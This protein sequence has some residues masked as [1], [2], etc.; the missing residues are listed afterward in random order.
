[1]RQ[2]TIRGQLTRRAALLA[3]GAIAGGFLGARYGAKVPPVTGARSLAP[4][5]AGGMLNDA[6]LLSETPVFRHAVLAENPGQALIARLRQEL[7]EARAEGRPV[8]IGAAR[9][10]MGGHAIPPGGHAVT[11]D[12]GLVEPDT[13]KG[14][15]RVHPGARWSQVIAQLD[16]VGMSPKVMQSN[17]DFGVA[18][19]FAVNAHGWPV[20][21]GPMG[22]T[23]RTIYML[24]P[25]GELLRVSRD[26]FADLFFLA[27]GGYGMTGA[28]I[29]MEVEMVPNRRLVPTFQKIAAKDFAPFFV[30]AIETG[31][32]NMAY[33]R[34]NVDRARFF[35]DAL[36]ITYRETRDQEDLPPAAGS[37]LVSR[38]SACIFRAQLMNE[39]AKELRWWFETD[40]GPMIGAGEVT[41]NS[42][43]N[44]PVIT[45]DD[46]DPSRTD[47]LH[48][49]FVPPE[50][51][52][53]FVA[54]CQDVIPSSYQEM[55]NITLRF[56]RADRESVLAY[57]PGNRIAAVMLFGQELTARAEADH[58]RM[59]RDLIDRVLDLGG[60]YYLPYRPHATRAQFLRSYPRAAEF[61]A[62]KIELDP[63][64]LF[65]NV[66]WDNY[67]EWLA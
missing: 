37:G 42:L 55:L 67:L 18:A 62:R 4:T 3:G 46:R 9:H 64:R 60:T 40:F 38:A 24:R 22:S 66:F 6:S 49:Y 35:E 48:E 51:F 23:V 16:R 39:T 29:D 21:W 10:S 53:D 14:V 19:T 15:Y 58:A 20:P 7:D 36:M 57:A 27:M 56:V 11:F 43:L 63:D 26:E 54:A 25:D 34:L 1:M 50:R 30:G 61:V 31:E 47:I 8:N 32:V 65:R 28:I 59:T 2:P 5:G 52:A 33:G 41:R 44:E 13:R 17:N 45:L 12:N